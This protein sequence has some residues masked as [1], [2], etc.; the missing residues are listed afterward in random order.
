MK[1]RGGP[2]R[3]GAA[4]GSDG[5]ASA[6]EVRSLELTEP[7]GWIH[8]RLK[9]PGDAADAPGLRAYLVQLVVL[10]NH[11][12]GRDTHVREV[13]V[14]GPRKC[15]KQASA[16]RRARADAPRALSGTCCRRRGTKTSRQSRSRSSLS[17]DEE[18]ASG[19]FTSHETSVVAAAE[20]AWL[21]TRLA[22]TSGEPV[23]DAPACLASWPFALLC[24]HRRTVG[25]AVPTCEARRR[26]HGGGVCLCV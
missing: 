1:A 13:K 3:V 9:R 8:V 7:S 19:R 22:R 12:N 2:L 6:Q 11:Q 17:S 10:T 25:A 15:A 21:C 24:K 16:P 26:G 5:A 23:N 20:R 4:R 14:F 18:A